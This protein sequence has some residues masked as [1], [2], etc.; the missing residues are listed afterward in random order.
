VEEKKKKCPT[1]LRNILYICKY[2]PLKTFVMA[3]YTFSKPYST[4]VAVGGAVGLRKY[5]WNAGDVIDAE[6]FTSKNPSDAPQVRSLVNPNPI[7]GADMFAYIPLSV[8]TAGATSGSGN[9]SAKT[10]QSFF[11]PK[12][13]VIG[14]L[15]NGAIFGLLKVT[16]V[17]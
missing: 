16:K 14:I 11:T 4:N 12:N 13:I 8:L 15:A 17:I 2:K 6:P 1:A 3:K 10:A 7:Q 5:S 9:G